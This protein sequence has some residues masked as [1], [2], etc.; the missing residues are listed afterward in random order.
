MNAAIANPTDVESQRIMGLRK[1]RHFID[2]ATH[3]D[4]ARVARVQGLDLIKLVPQASA[5]DFPMNDAEKK[6]LES[7]G[8]KVV[9]APWTVPPGITYGT[10]P[11]A[12]QDFVRL[13]ALALDE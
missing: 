2:D 7:M 1:I 4:L 6:S 13:N 5:A 12:K 10:D 9:F 11:C 8:F 3:K